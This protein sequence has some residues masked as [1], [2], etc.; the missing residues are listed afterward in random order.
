MRSPRR[1]YNQNSP[2][3]DEVRTA[4]AE[5]RALKRVDVEEKRKGVLRLHRLDVG[6]T[7]IARR[8]KV[9]EEFVKKVLAEAGH[10]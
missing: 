5:G 4:F 1:Q 9:G 2:C 10:A 8:L 7:D 6:K 3:M